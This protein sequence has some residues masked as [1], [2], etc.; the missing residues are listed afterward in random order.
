MG[1]VIVSEN[2]LFLAVLVVIGIL[3]L[4]FVPPHIDKL[5]NVKLGTVLENDYPSNQATERR[6]LIN[7]KID[8]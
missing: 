6:S 3:E 4:W 8:Y 7:C 2:Q 5:S 1:G